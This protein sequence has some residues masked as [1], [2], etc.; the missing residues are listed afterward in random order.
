VINLL[1]VCVKHEYKIYCSQNVII[2]SAKVILFNL[3]YIDVNVTHLPLCN[4]NKL[5]RVYFLTMLINYGA[6]L[7]N[8]GTEECVE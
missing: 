7:I 3:Q 5:K 6:A 2:L 4:F 1:S 8:Y